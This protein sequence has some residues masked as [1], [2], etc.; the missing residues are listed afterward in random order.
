MDG[1]LLRGPPYG[2]D[3]DP[4]N[5]A[6]SADD[7]DG[8]AGDADD[9]DDPGNDD[10]PSAVAPEASGLPTDRGLVASALHTVQ[11][12][13]SS[14]E[15]DGHLLRGPPYGVDRDPSDPGDAIAGWTGDSNDAFGDS[16]DDNDDDDDG[17]DAPGQAVA[18]VSATLSADHSQV[19]LKIH[20]EIDRRSAFASDGHS[21][22][23]P[24]Q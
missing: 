8:G 2:L 12:D 20:D 4:S 23:A 5:P 19:Q 6:W 17:D 10:A 11:D 3:D 14:H 24:P 13:P 18:A 1:H 9:D 7:P 15:M 22:R 21:L 16:F